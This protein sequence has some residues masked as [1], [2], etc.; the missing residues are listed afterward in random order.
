M[1][2]EGRSAGPIPHTHSRREPGSPPAL[3]DFTPAHLYGATPPFRFRS[4]SAAKVRPW[5]AFPGQRAS[6]VTEAAAMGAHLVRRYLGDA[7]IEPDPLR[8][9][10]FD[11]LYGLPERR[12]RGETPRAPCP[13]PSEPWGAG[14]VRSRGRPAAA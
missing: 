7:E 1:V 9:P 11:P 2:W 8:M 12:E 10:S 13:L 6:A 4:G 3:L 5:E 14:P